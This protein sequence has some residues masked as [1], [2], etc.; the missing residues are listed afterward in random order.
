[1]SSTSETALIFPSVK[2]RDVDPRIEQL[3]LELNHSPVSP[4]CWQVAAWCACV[5]CYIRYGR[6]S[7]IWRMSSG[8]RIWNE[9]RSDWPMPF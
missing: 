5:A 3:S 2:R 1:M 7:T 9:L 8:S 6:R 4:G